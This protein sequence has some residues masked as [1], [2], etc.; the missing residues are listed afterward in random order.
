MH[1]PG[2]I[3]MAGQQAQLKASCA[4]CTALQC[5]HA[6]KHGGCCH[7]LMHGDSQHALPWTHMLALAVWLGSTTSIVQ[8]AVGIQPEGRCLLSEAWP[9]S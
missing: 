1:G 7:A 4:W 5:C 6:L 3:H 8:V 2:V 9:K